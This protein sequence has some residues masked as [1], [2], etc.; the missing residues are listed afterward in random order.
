MAK[1][2]DTKVI[3]ARNTIIGFITVVAIAILGFGTYVSTDLSDAEIVANQDYR[4]LDNPRPRRASDPIEV[5]EFFSYGCVHCRNFDSLVDEWAADLPEDVVFKKQ[6]ATFSPIW[7]L[8]SQTYLTLESAGVLEQN[9][10]R[11]FRAIH[12]A[13]RQFLTAE[14][15]ADYIDGRGL[16]ADEFLR[17]FNSP[18]VRDAMRDADRAQ[19]E[20]Q[21]AS[22]PSLVVAGKYLVTMD[23]G[24]RRALR[25]VDQLIDEERAA[26][27]TN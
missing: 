9:H 16:S 24:Q 22:T 3:M 14:M 18:R 6:P 13:G 11:M 8:L 5:V 23:G 15:V 1:K 27:A 2:K 25:I 7:A 26:T 19:R 17:E 12:D 10:D 21:I 4:V 20:Y